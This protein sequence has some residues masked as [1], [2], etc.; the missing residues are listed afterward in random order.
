MAKYIINYTETL[1]HDF[2]VE[3]DSEDGALA[4]FE[5]LVQSNKIDFSNGEVSNTEV[6]AKPVNQK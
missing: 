4:E 3:A 5:R 6:C 2:L 1:S